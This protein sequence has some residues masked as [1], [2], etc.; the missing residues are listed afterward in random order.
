M[1]R[2]IVRADGRPTYLLPDIAYHLDKRA[3]GFRRAINLW[4]PDHHAYVATLDG[5]ARR[6]PGSR[7]DF[8]HVLIVQ[9][10]NLLRDGQDQ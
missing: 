9:Q 10:V 6:R 5:G 1:D 7:P 8:L 2:V 4:G 3:R